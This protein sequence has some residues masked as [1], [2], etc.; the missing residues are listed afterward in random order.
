MKDLVGWIGGTRPAARAGMPLFRRTLWLSVST[1]LATA[2]ASPAPTPATSPAPLAQSPSALSVMTPEARDVVS[3]SAVSF[4]LLPEPYAH[5]AI[6]TSGPHWSALS[7]RDGEL[8]VSL[9]GTDETH[10]AQLTLAETQRAEPRAMV[11]GQRARVLVNEG[12][13]SVAW[14]EEGVDWSLEVECYQPDQDRRC[15]ADAFVLDLAE[16][17]ERPR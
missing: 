5:L 9:H 10:D 16:H 14:N 3:A 11:R 8:T 15:T 12:I 13:R 4:L 7:A 17:L 1:A 2:C 6:A